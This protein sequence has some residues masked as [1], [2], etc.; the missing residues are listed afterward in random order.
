MTI[1]GLYKVHLARITLGGWLI[2]KC[3]N[4]HNPCTQHTKTNRNEMQL[5]CQFKSTNC[6]TKNFYVCNVK[7]IQLQR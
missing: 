3:S 6:P 4:N 2:T 5:N 7:V 1:S